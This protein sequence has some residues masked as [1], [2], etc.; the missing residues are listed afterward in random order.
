MQRLV[1][2]YE[3]SGGFLVAVPS[4]SAEDCPGLVVEQAMAPAVLGPSIM[5]LCVLIGAVA[6]LA[7]VRRRYG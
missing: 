5:L 7:A 3:Q 4:V 6:A 1:C 2:L